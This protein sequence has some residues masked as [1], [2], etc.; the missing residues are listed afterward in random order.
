VSQAR[1]KERQILVAAM[2]IA[3]AGGPF[4]LARSADVDLDPVS[5]ALSLMEMIMTLA[6]GLGG[7][8]LVDAK[9]MNA[10]KAR[11]VRL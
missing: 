2:L 7:I 10:A 3:A 6:V 9:A 1:R 8:I 4:L 11:G 5:F